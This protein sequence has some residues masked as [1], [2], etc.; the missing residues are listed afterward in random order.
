[1]MIF[2]LGFLILVIC[3]LVPDCDAFL[4]RCV[5]SIDPAIPTL[6]CS[7]FNT[8]LENVLDRRRSCPFDVS[9]LCFWIVVWWIFGVKGTQMVR[10]GPCLA[11]ISCPYGWVPYVSSVDILPCPFLFK[12]LACFGF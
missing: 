11:L 12:I 5:D 8:V 2:F 4:V 3:V 9:R 7:D 1:M 10:W 6:L